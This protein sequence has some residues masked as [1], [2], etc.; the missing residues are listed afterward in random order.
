[1]QLTDV[2]GCFDD[3][4]LHVEHTL[5]TNIL[6]KHSTLLNSYLGCGASWDTFGVI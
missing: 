1:M 6:A 5:D 3:A 2:P 4:L